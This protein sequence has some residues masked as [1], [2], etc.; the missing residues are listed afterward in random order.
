M[1]TA[2]EGSRTKYFLFSRE[3]EMKEHLENLGKEGVIRKRVRELAQQL[4]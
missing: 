4:Q 1:I 2:I 3:T